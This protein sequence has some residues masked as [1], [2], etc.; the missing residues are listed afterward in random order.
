MTRTWMKILAVS[1]LSFSLLSG[2]TMNFAAELPS[3]E[4]SGTSA[5]QWG[6]AAVKSEQVYTLEDMLIYAIQDE[7]SAQAEYEAIMNKFNVSRPFSNIMKAEVTHISYLKPLFEKYDVNIPSNTASEH[8][9][10]PATVQETYAIGVEAEIKN[11]AMY[12]VFLK[13]ELPSDVRVVFE[14]LKKASESHLR[15]FSRQR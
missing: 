8:V 1:T 13:Q 15:A 9:I 4:L 6:S 2:M 14:A 3:N 5:S 7:F 10:L 12:D 11:I